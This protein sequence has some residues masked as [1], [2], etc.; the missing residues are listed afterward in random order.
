MLHVKHELTWN[1]SVPMRE[2]G[3][4]L[5]SLSANNGELSDAL[6]PHFNVN[7]VMKAIWLTIVASCVVNDFTDSTVGLVHVNP[8]DNEMM[9]AN[10][11]I[12]NNFDMIFKFIEL[13]S[14][15]RGSLF[16]ELQWNF[17]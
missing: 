17:N 3:D 7:S 11:Q 10:A 12:N 2:T 6:F 15:N 4:S 8:K 14:L 1:L 9:A 13:R 16:N 5:P